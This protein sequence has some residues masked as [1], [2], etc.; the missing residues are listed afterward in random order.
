MD[1][2][3]PEDFWNL[4]AA[5]RLVAADA[6]A[7]LRRDYESAPGADRP[8]ATV[9]IAQWLVGRGV[10]TLWQAKRLAR[11]DRGPYFVGDYRLLVRLPATGQSGLFRARHE[12]SGRVVQISVLK[13]AAC[14]D[15]KVWTAIVRRTTIAHQ[16]SD[17]LLSRTWALEQ[18]GANRFI[19]CEDLPDTTL[20]DELA[21]A[22][23]LP[24]AEACGL[25]L[26]VARAVA[27]LHRLGAVHGDVSLDTLRR[28]P[29]AAGN[30]PRTGD[31]RLAQFPQTGDPHQEV[32]RVPTD[33]P[34]Q[35]EALGRRAAF[36]APELM[37]PDRVC[38]TRSDVYAIGCVFHALVTGQPPCW[39]GDAQRTL[40][41]AAFVGVPPLAPPT[42][43]VEIATLIGYMTARDP[44]GRYPSAVEAADAIAACLGRGPVSPSLPPQRPMAAPAAAPPPPPA[45]VVAAASAIHATQPATA[46]AAVRQPFAESTVTFP[47]AVAESR[48]A[49]RRDAMRPRRGRRPMLIAAG[50]VAAATA[51]TA[52]F[53]GWPAPRTDD[54]GPQPPPAAA[55]A[56]PPIAT[57]PMATATDDPPDPAEPTSSGATPPRED[58]PPV[59]THT[60]VDDPSLAWGSPTSGPSP[61]LAYLPPGAQ[62]ILLARPAEITADE[63]GTLFLE[64]LGP[65][66]TA[67]LDA[68][69]TICGCGLDGIDTI[70]A[71]WQ[72]AVTGGPVGGYAVHLREP[73][74]ATAIATAIGSRAKIDVE[75]ETIHEG[76][77]IGCW[78]PSAEQDRV[79]VLGTTDTLREIIAADAAEPAASS[80]LRAALTPDMERLVAMLDSTRH[81]TIVAAP[82]YLFND[83]RGVM[84]GPLAKL[85]DPLEAFC[86]ESLRAAALS[87]HFGDDFYAELDA[88]ST[89][90]EPARQ[91]AGR[92]GDQ[93]GGLAATVEEYCAQLDLA[94]YGR[95][96][97]MRLPGMIR[98][99]ADAT[100]S[101]V[102]GK[103]VVVNCY[104]PRHAGH[105]LALAAE[106]ALQQSPGA[107]GRATAAAPP[108][109]PLT[110]AAALQKKMTLTFAKDTLEKSIQMMAEEIGMAMEIR[111]PDLQLEGI[112]K[113][114][115]FGLEERDKT[116]AEILR[117][118]LA[119]AN[120]DGK[121]VYVIRK[122]DGGERIDI[123][124]KA[125]AAKRGD[126]L[127]PGFQ[128]ADAETSPSPGK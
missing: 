31:V 11:G 40:A 115:S 56:S 65:A 50:L 59:K 27:H 66:V 123:T 122:G 21:A 61:T 128:A 34:R 70:Q 73:A 113:N 75:G 68:V 63:E 120:P 39:Q 5:S 117:V 13:P 112:T 37:L 54:P 32:P 96:L 127:P 58:R 43:P 51:A 8:A 2:P 81:L 97:V 98:I 36:V 92:F 48:A 10:I 30:P 14:R 17:P 41:H 89:V 110:A 72:A 28:S 33:D 111:G 85:I 99:L 4:L 86:G 121:L 108:G 16:A 71:G 64:A 18:A 7:D 119:K 69:Q 62:L 47:T 76:Q 3:S 57:A 23:P 49:P 87:L 1:T 74:D 106:L 93:I 12:P 24:V 118:I 67:A 6:V 60:L 83:G 35:I 95:K 94:P 125:A 25:A 124:T 103:S 53:L 44:A 45:P 91:L 90:D 38:D 26:D 22:G 80:G 105:N 42:V 126:P 79:I 19:V 82:H 114:Q 116:A 109:A 88:V 52:F 102:E 77:A 107:V 78:L 29:A 20:A 100:R 46:S 55:T 101:A 15:V 84:A 9:A 104:L